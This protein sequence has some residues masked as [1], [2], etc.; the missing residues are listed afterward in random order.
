[1]TKR[2]KKISITKEIRDSVIYTLD[3]L[4]ESLDLDQKKVILREIGLSKND[5]EKIDESGLKTRY[6]RDF[7]TEFDKQTVGKDLRTAR[8]T[9]KYVKANELISDKNNKLYKTK[10]KNYKDE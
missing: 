8:L 1:M 5:I 3:I 10:I 2:G 6:V 9:D 4:F 7:M